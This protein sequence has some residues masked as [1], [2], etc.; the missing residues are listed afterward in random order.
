MPNFA[1]IFT[2]FSGIITPDSRCGTP[3]HTYRPARSMA[4]RRDACAFVVRDLSSFK[5]CM[6]NIL[7]LLSCYTCERI[8][9][10][11][12]GDNYLL[13]VKASD[14]DESHVSHQILYSCSHFRSSS[15]VN[16]HGAKKS[17]VHHRGKH[18]RGR[19]KANETTSLLLWKS[20]YVSQ[21]DLREQ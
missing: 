2:K 17:A 21:E 13:D 20:C 8:P 7:L 19:W 1:S 3:S 16:L 6:K 15:I 11:T 12:G 10:S 14:P 9:S 5:F 18:K 4:M